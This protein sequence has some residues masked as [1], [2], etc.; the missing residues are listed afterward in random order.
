[1]QNQSVNQLAL[2]SAIEV[3]YVRSAVNRLA[4]R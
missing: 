3:G 2:D 4:I 1:M